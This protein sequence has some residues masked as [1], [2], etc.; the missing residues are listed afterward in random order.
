MEFFVGEFVGLR[1]RDD[2]VHILET[3]EIFGGKTAF[4]ANHADD[5][6]LGPPGK[7]GVQPASLDIICDC[8]YAAFRCARLHDDD[9]GF[10]FLSAVCLRGGGENP[11]RPFFLL[12]T[13]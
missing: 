13:I 7:V 5:G 12:K 10:L 9:H 6:D 4:V 11:R 2:T 3:D 1:N 8:L